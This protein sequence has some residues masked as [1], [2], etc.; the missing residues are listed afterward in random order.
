MR[1]INIFLVMLISCSAIETHAISQTKTYDMVV[2]I[3]NNFNKIPTKV[4]QALQ[5]L[6]IIIDLVNKRNKIRSELVPHSTQIEDSTSARALFDEFVIPIHNTNQKINGLTS[7]LVKDL[8]VLQ[9]E[10]TDILAEAQALY[11]IYR[12][13]I[14]WE[15]ITKIQKIRD[16][17]QNIIPEVER[18]KQQEDLGLYVSSR[19]AKLRP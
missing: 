8:N 2:Q 3:V 17:L 9:T 7:T 15:L 1:N 5:D 4:H 10:I 19:V 14:L 18:A 11:H 6:A 12:S 13:S 16:G